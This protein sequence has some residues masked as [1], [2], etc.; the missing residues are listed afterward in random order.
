MD[1]PPK[2]MSRYNAVLI[3]IA[4]ML[5]FVAST[6][7]SFTAVE[8]IRMTFNRGGEMTLREWVWGSVIS[9]IVLFGFITV[10]KI[11]LKAVNNVST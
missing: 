11:P 9:I 6:F 3:F 10:F 4:I 5:L 1:P 8:V 7:V 2:R